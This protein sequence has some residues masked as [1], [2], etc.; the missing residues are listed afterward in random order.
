MIF[1]E[2]EVYQS[3][4]DKYIKMKLLGK[5]KYVGESFGV[6]GLTSDKIYNCVG[7][8]I[9]TRL[10]SIV[11]DSEENY[12]YPIDNPKPLDGSSKGGKW[13]IIEIYDEKLKDILST[14]K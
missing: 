5:L 3:N 8:D 7:Y 10:L 1:M 11:D 4:G 9:E 2:I 12:M 13:E 14:Q 6:E